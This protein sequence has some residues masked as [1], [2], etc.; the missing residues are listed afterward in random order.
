MSV[1]IA[2]ESFDATRSSD[3]PNN[4]NLGDTTASHTFS[5]CTT[6]LLV[7]H[8]NRRAGIELIFLHNENSRASHSTEL[9][10]NSVTDFSESGCVV[11][12]VPVRP[13]AQPR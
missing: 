13:P 2:K 12:S 9:P 7:S 10:E 6:D 11:C 4:V 8:E 5:I 1:R 3:W